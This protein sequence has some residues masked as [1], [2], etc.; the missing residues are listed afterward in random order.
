MTC[1]RPNRKHNGNHEY[2][3]LRIIIRISIYNEVSYREDW[4]DRCYLECTGK[5]MIVYLH[6][7]PT[8]LFTLYAFS[9]SNYFRSHM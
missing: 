5:Q 4:F 6:S 3:I 2:K 1:V 8:V 9:F 7:I